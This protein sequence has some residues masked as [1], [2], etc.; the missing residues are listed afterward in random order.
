MDDPGIGT[1]ELA[2]RE[3]QAM[4]ERKT[5]TNRWIR[6]A[7]VALGVLLALCAI[8]FFRLAF[9]GCRFPVDKSAETQA[10]ILRAAVQSWQT[11]TGSVTCPTLQQLIAEK[12]LHRDTATWIPGVVPID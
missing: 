7:V 9:G 3:S 1:L 2:F 8:A 6:S 11:E 12:H 10:R 5:A 4:T